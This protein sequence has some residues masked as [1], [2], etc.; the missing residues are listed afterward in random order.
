MGRR[1]GSSA[2][3]RRRSTIY[4]VAKEAGVSAAPGFPVLK[5]TAAISG[6]TR[7][8]GVGGI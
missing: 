2:G 6:G 8:R 5:G 1:S 3:E 4:D 7:G